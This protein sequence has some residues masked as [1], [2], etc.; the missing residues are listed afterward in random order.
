MSLL[1]ANG[2]WHYQFHPEVWVLLAVGIALSLYAVRVIGPMVV[3][4]GEPIVTVAQ[5]R[6]FIAGMLLFWVAA[7]WPLH[8]IAENYLYSAHMVQHLLVTFIIPPLLLLALPE[9][10][11]R[12]VFLEGGMVSRIMRIITKPVVAGLAFNALQ[13]F[14]YWTWTVNTSSSNGNFHYTMH[15][16]YFFLGM[17]MWF[18]VLGPLKELQMSE[19]GKMIYLFL[20][21]IIPT[22]PA[23]WLAFAGDA[24]YRSYD[25][26]YRMWGMSVQQDQ[27]IAGAIMKVAGGMYLWL[28]IAIRFFRLSAGQQRR[29]LERRRLNTPGHTITYA[30]VTREFAEAGDPPREMRPEKA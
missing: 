29:D 18:P 5:K 8:D 4:E 24:V 25:I 15:V 13:L 30:D 7:D 28:L 19:M 6:F 22:V 10:L 16:S 12:L 1:A 17:L 26:P 9:W 2:P 3:P 20:M 14:G 21:S 27:Q 11:A 23:G